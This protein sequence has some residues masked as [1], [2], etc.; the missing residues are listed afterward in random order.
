MI[1]VIA[2]ITALPGKRSEILEAFHAN[3]PAVLAEKGCIEYRPVIDVEDA[4]KIQSKLGADTFTVIEK[5]ETME[6]LGAHAQSAHMAAYGK[7]VA[8][9]ISDRKIHVFEDTQK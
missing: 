2:I 9:R 5:W 8:D 3:I 4:G 7:Q 6:D 1:H